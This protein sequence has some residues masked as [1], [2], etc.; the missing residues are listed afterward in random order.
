MV[1]PLPTHEAI[2][3]KSQL[4]NS[5]TRNVGNATPHHACP[6][7]KSSNPTCGITLLWVRNPFRGAPTTAK[8]H[9]KKPDALFPN[10]K[11]HTIRKMESGKTIEE[12][13]GCARVKRANKWH[14]SMIAT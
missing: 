7:A 8:R 6:E 9:S 11:L 2:T 1:Y 12:S 14:N 3:T 10:K 13:S 4:C 5:F